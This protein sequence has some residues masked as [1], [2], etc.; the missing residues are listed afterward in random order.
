MKWRCS[1]TKDAILNQIKQTFMLKRVRAEEECDEFVN[2]LREDK[3]FDNMY[4]TLTAKRIEKFRS[5]NETLENE[6]KELQLKIKTYLISKNIDYTRLSPKYDC[7]DC[8]DTGI[9]GG[10]MCHCLH[11]ALNKALL[12]QGSLKKSFSRFSDANTKLMDD[13]DIKAMNLLKTWTEKYPDTTKININLIGGAGMGKTFLMECVASALID[14]DISAVFVS[15]FELNESARR[16]HIG[17]AYD[18]SN[19]IDAEVLLIDDLGTEPILKN[20]TKEYLYNLINIRQNNNRPTIISTNLSLD[21]LLDR[22]DERIF[23][24]LCNK[25]YSINIQLTSKDK[26][27]N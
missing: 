16:Y 3:D 12:D 24:R 21:N 5:D 26:R 17:K 25:A 10:K 18:F 22:Y 1:M 6:I 9:S 14:K 13:N 27:V 2:R 11:Q 4:S 20:V 23:S 15:A 7:P 19:Y 8:N